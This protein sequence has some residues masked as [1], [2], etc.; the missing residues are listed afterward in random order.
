MSSTAGTARFPE[1]NDPYVTGLEGFRDDLLFDCLLPCEY[2][3]DAFH[4]G[5]EDHFDFVV[6][7]VHR[8]FTI[9]NYALVLDIG[10]VGEMITLACLPRIF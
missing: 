3:V 10:T 6:D 2:L 7:F 5:L 1:I 4:L 8:F 9:I